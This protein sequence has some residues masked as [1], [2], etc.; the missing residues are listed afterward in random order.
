VSDRRLDEVL[1]RVR[2]E[3]GEL[4]PDRDVELH[5]HVTERVDVV[6]GVGDVAG[7]LP[8]KRHRVASRAV[9][10]PRDRA[11]AEVVLRAVRRSRRADDHAGVVDVASM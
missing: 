3:P 2:S 10:R 11:P 1:H 7:K 5:D 6:C 9:R 4:H 8:Q